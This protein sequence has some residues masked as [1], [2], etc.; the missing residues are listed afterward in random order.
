MAKMKP[1]LIGISGTNGAGKDTVGGIL[2]DA[3]GYIF[4]S[5]TV[6]MRAE[7]ERRGCP[8]DREHMRELS[9]EWRREH[10]L[11]VLVDKACEEHSEQVRTKSGLAIASL[12][13]PA[14][15]DRVHELGGIVIW[16][17]ADPRVRYNRVQAN[18]AVRNRADEDNRTFEQ[19]L[20]EEQAEMHTSGD[21]ATLDMAA[22]KDR[23]DYTIINEFA[24]PDGLAGELAKLL[25]R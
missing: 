25:E 11:A 21:A 19:F 15:A 16:I 23:C 9:A 22:V 13:N 18:A 12:R 3:F 5:V 2:A 4:T 20:A 10:G 7:L 17:D 24:T 8:T 6:P 1:T 14:E